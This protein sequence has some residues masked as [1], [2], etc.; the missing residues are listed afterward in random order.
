[1]QHSESTPSTSTSQPEPNSAKPTLTSS[2]IPSR[3]SSPQLYRSRRTPPSGSRQTTQRKDPRTARRLSFGAGGGS[4]DNEQGGG[5]GD[6]SFAPVPPFNLKALQDS[7]EAI[8]A[9]GG[10]S[11][12]ASRAESGSR[13]I[14]GL[15]Q[16]KNAK[17]KTGIMVS[18]VSLIREERC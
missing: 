5:G 2:P 4:H 16:T 18:N 15:P 8:E 12:A 6:F 13:R 1:M 17:S 7:L 9:E 14:A 10:K 3:F 11:R